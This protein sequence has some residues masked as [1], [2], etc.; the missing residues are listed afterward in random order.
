MR[1]YAAELARKCGSDEAGEAAMHRMLGHY[2]HSACA[3]RL[4]IQPLAFPL[5][6][7][8]V[9]PGVRPEEP[10]DLEHAMAWFAVE[11]PVLLS[12]LG[13]AVRSHFDRYALQLPLAMS[14]YLQLTGQWQE[15]IDTLHASL[16]AARRL[17]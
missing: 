15:W 6:P 4:L 2:L 9:L 12:V 1:V 14:L 11:R 7:V 3:A 8:P 13:A 10:G 16:A 17:G 5:E